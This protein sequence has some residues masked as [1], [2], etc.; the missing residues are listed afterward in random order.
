MQLRHSPSNSRVRSTFLGVRPM[1]LRCL[2]TKTSQTLFSSGQVQL[3]KP[4]RLFSR[5]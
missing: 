5:R 4:V 2:N 3:V 1:V